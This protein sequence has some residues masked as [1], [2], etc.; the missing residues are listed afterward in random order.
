MVI[1]QRGEVNRG[2]P[3]SEQQRTRPGFAK[4]E[5]ITGRVRL[6][7][8]RRPPPFGDHRWGH[9]CASGPGWTDGRPRK[10]LWQLFDR[11]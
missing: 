7:M 9:L 11:I 8:T 3:G 10:S 2:L 6:V 5:S 4:I 1:F